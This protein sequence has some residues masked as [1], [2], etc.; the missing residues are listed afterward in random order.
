MQGRAQRLLP[1]RFKHSRPA[2]QAL[3]A[4][5]VCPSWAVPGSPPPPPPP[6]PPPVD[7]SHTPVSV[8]QTSP[9]RHSSSYQ[10]SPQWPSKHASPG[11]QSSAVEHS[12]GTQLPLP[13]SQM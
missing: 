5:Q 12:A 8:S 7:T 10:H 3:V 4:E 1:P 9:V 11:S 13:V 2:A 6:P